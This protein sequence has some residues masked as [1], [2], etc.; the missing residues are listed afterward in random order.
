MRH[1]GD[2]YGRQGGRKPLYMRRLTR[3]S[4]QGGK[5]PKPES[6]PADFVGLDEKQSRLLYFLPAADVE[7]GLI[8]PK[9]QLMQYPNLN[10][11]KKMLDSHLYIFSRWVLD[12]LDADKD[13]CS[14]KTELIPFLVR[15]TTSHARS[16]ASSHVR[17]F[18]H[19]ASVR[20][21]SQ[22]L[23]IGVGYTSLQPPLRHAPCCSCQEVAPRSWDSAE[24]LG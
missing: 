22:G 1:R 13:I 19:L 23:G 9:R 5:P 2:R 7:D 15:P 12:L 16:F 10:V 21:R 8:I 4:L 17:T 18:D 14:I 20:E 3:V 24:S 6:G 11:T